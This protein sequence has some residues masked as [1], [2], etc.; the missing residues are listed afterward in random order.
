MNQDGLSF[1]KFI[2]NNI[3]LFL[4]KDGNMYFEIPNSAITETIIDLVKDNQK[5]NNKIFKDFEGNNRVIKI[6]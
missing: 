1:Y 2:I 3:D 5:I 6:Y 4:E